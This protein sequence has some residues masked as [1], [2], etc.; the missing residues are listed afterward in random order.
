VFSGAIAREDAQD[1][2]VA[3]VISS[4][5][6]VLGYGYYNS[7]SQIRLRMLSFGETPFTNDTLRTLISASI[8][9]RK[10][11][12]LLDGTD[13]VR[14]IFSEGDFLPGLIVDSYNGHLV[15]Q[16]LTLGID[17]MKD[18][19]VQILCDITR[20]PGIYERSDYPG[21]ELEGLKPAS[22]QLSGATPD[23]IIITEHG[24]RY[25]INVKTGQKT[26]FFIDQR[27]NR[28]LIGQIAQG[29]KVLNLFCYTGGF[30]FAA[31]RGGASE[32][33]SVDISASALDS[34]RRVYE[35]N[36]FTQKAEFIE[37]DV[38]EYLRKAPITANCIILDPPAFVKSRGDVDKACRGYKDI[39]L[40]LIKKCPAGSFVLT[41]SCSRFIDMDLFQK[42]VFSA[43]SDARRDAQII[44]KTAHP[45]DHPVNLNH[46]ETEYLKG[47]LLYVR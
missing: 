40:Q 1:G 19:I 16:C 3:K 18:D 28:Q 14:L 37:A 38:F 47:I 39:N 35:L 24:V 21:R 23:E 45:A 34:A 26:G 43:A 2:S 44:R 27:E 8:S 7:R 32:A 15:L 12:P 33:A 11:N 9:T 25:P 22:G 5:G 17:A 13:A 36:G 41:C 29:R 42:V 6:E 30:T 4:A 10:Q 31:L 46:P 20:C